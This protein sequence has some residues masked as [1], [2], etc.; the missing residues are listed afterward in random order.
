VRACTGSSCKRFF[1][2]VAS[3]AVG[4]AN[5]S[6]SL[7][8]VPIVI[9]WWTRGDGRKGKVGERKEGR[10]NGG[11]DHDDGKRNALTRQGRSKQ[12]TSKHARMRSGT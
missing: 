7:L 6:S 12:N 3:V 9:V 8:D 11:A 5:D 10:A 4:V 1:A 2:L